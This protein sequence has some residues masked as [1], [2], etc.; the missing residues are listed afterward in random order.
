MLNNVFNSSMEKK[1]WAFFCSPSL[2]GILS[3]SSKSPVRFSLD[4][5]E[6]NFNHSLSAADC[7]GSK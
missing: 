3:V 5:K 1:E 6:L 7:H 4:F 2:I